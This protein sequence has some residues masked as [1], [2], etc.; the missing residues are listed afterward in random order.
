M[1]AARRQQAMEG[2][3]M[4]RRAM[5]QQAQAAPTQEQGVAPE[6][7]PQAPMGRG[8]EM[9]R[10]V[11][12]GRMPEMRSGINFGPGR[13][14]RVP[15]QGSPE[16]EQLLQRVRGLNQMSA[17]SSKKIPPQFLEYLKKKDAKKEDGSEMNDKEKRKAAL[18][19]ARKYQESRRKKK[20]D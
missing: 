19:K 17:M 10:T 9:G 12:M 5:Q 20:E 3:A 15:E 6:F 18:D 1:D 2:Q 7:A 8:P 16:Y 4:R 11:G 14:N 13:A